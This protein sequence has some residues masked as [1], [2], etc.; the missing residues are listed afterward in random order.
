MNR[1]MLLC[2][3]ALLNSPAFADEA[4]TDNERCFPAKS[5]AKMKDNLAKIPK[6]NLGYIEQNVSAKFTV[7]DE[8]GLPEQ[9][10]YRVDGVDTV[11][12][13]AEDGRVAGILSPETLSKNGKYC[14]IDPVRAAA[15]RADPDI[16][17]A[18]SFSMEVEAVFPR[19]TLYTLTDLR[20]GLTD[21]RPVYKKMFGAMGFMVPKLTHVSIGYEDKMSSPDIE[22]VKDGKA[23][24]GLD[25]KP[26]G[27]AWLVEITQLEAIGANG[28]RINDN[29]KIMEP[30]VSIEMMKK[31]GF[32]EDEG[33]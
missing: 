30:G 9:F 25:L 3:A 29:F 21:G 17:T 20:R 19:Q 22:A 11:L 28:L 7:K 2:A 27:K 12:P 14:I 8:Y 23:I 33:E 5:I 13:I 18:V 6:K 31:F 26:F 1:T 16:E 24:G 10:V 4:A 32:T 15:K